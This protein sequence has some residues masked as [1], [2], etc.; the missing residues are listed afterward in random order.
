MFHITPQPHNYIFKSNTEN[1]IPQELGLGLES[2]PFTTLNELKEWS[3]NKNN[4]M[5]DSESSVGLED[6]LDQNSGYGDGEQYLD[7]ESETK[8]IRSESIKSEI[9]YVNEPPKKKKVANK[10]KSVV[11]HKEAIEETW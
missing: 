2:T 11:L 6:F 10:S 8:S 3:M 7:Y 1:P 5:S 4:T 9:C